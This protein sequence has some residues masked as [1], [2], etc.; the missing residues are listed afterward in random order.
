MS[1]AASA[2]PRPQFW[3]LLERKTVLFVLNSHLGGNFLR[4]LASVSRAVCSVA[5]P[6]QDT[7]IMATA[8]Q[9]CV[10]SQ[11]L[12]PGSSLSSWA[13]AGHI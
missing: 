11:R 3:S 9:T 5:H 12:F 7:A 4:A 1:A 8:A 2:S 6:A 10:A 13:P